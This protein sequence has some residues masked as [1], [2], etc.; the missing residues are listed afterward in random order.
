M[1]T[2]SLMLGQVIGDVLDQFDRSVSLRIMYNNRQVFTGTQLMPSAVV[3]KPRVE[4]GG[5]DLRVLYTLVMV[6]P[7]APNPS[8]PTLREYLHW[9]VTDI[10]ATTDVSFGK[11]VICYESPEP[12][13]GIHRMVFALFRQIGRETVIAPQVRSNFNTRHF[14]RQ[15][16]LGLPV[17]AAFFTCHREGGTGGRRIN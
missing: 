5:N 8:N 15:H 14:A 10:P 7:D 9:L 6:D 4:V 12:R 13:S 16:N 3:N 17:A 11:E 1:S 2:D